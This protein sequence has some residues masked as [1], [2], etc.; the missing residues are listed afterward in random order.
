MDDSIWMVRMKWG[1]FLLKF[2]F[3][4]IN[5]FQAW[6]C[7]TDLSTPNNRRKFRAGRKEATFPK[8]GQEGLRNR[9]GWAVWPSLLGRRIHNNRYKRNFLLIF[10]S[11]NK[12]FFGRNRTW[13]QSQHHHGLFNQWFSTALLGGQLPGRKKGHFRDWRCSSH[14]ADWTTAPKG[15]LYWLGVSPKVI[16][17][18]YFVRK[19]VVTIS[20]TQGININNFWFSK[21]SKIFKLNSVCVTGVWDTGEQVEVN[22]RIDA[23]HQNPG[24]DQDDCHGLQPIQRWAVCIS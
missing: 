21:V 5:F 2:E 12:Y 3:I 20:E 18:W 4:F 15:V 19:K 16:A 23:L 1:V 14:R 22:Q 6:W 11:L 8:G 13:S 7:R 17:L 9:L 10:S 24:G